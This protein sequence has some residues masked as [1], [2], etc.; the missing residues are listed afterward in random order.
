MRLDDGIASA[1]TEYG[2]ERNQITLDS[3]TACGSKRLGFLA[4]QTRNFADTAMLA[5]AGTSM[6]YSAR[7][8]SFPPTAPVLASP[9]EPVKNHDQRKGR[10]GRK[11]EFPMIS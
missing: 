9:S 10:E 11:E 8:R 6:S 7:L 3:E 5:F 2:L 4:H 1:V